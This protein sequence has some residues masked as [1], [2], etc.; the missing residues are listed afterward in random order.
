MKFRKRKIL[1]I[2][3]CLAISLGIL[4]GDCM[5]ALADEDT[6]N[7][8]GVGKYGMTAIHG[9]Y[10]KDGTYD[11]KVDSN[12]K[13]FKVVKGTLKVENGEMTGS[14]EIG[15]HSYTKFFLGTGKEAKEA[16]ESD[17]V[18]PEEAGDSYIFTFPVKALNTPIDVAAYSKRKKK[19]YDRKILFDATTLPKG[20]LTI[21]LPDFDAIEK[22]M[23]GSDDG[24]TTGNDDDRKT[25]NGSYDN[26]VYGGAAGDAYT[27]AEAVEVP[28]EDGEYSIEVSMAGGTGRVTISSPTLMIVKDGKAYA[29]ILMSS[30][31]YDWMVA[32]GVKYENENTDGGNSYFIIPITAMDTLVNIVANTNA[33]GDPVA[34][35][36]TLTFYSETIG[37]KGQIP[38]EA[39]KKVI[40]VAAIIIVVLAILNYFVKKNRKKVRKK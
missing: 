15:S 34:I 10:V 16:N 12:N 28:Y 17:Y 13:Y 35:Q 6:A 39:A 21:D 11:I 14:I 1:R 32:A 30:S 37:N 25:G 40:I 2:V 38:Q 7:D 33:M 3:L 24:S 4:M 5:V 19:W 36:Y 26:G 27:P 22:A 9:S 31:H 23:S 29:K 20:T 18:M 8:S